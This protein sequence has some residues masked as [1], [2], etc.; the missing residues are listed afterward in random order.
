MRIGIPR[1]WA[2]L[3]V[4]CC[5]LLPMS[6]FGLSCSGMRDEYFVICKEGSCKAAFRVHEIRTSGACGRRSVVEEIPAGV[7]EVLLKQLKDPPITG[8]FQI[9]LNRRYYGSSLST[10]DEIVTAFRESDWPAPRINAQ[11][12][13]DGRTLQAIRSEWESKAMHGL[14]ETWLYWLAEV[15]A[16]LVALLVVFRS[17]YLFRK[18]VRMHLF[19][20]ENALNIGRY[21]GVQ[22]LVFVLGCGLGLNPVGLILIALV[23]PLLLVIWPFEFAIYLVAHAKSVKEK[24]SSI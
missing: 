17:T 6:S 11:K 18:K 10:V 15:G 1:I 21:I 3:L 23:I 24:R 7:T 5:L 2:K 9:S 13:E 4:V 8:T 12:L 22:I 16:L 14:W 19:G 20:G